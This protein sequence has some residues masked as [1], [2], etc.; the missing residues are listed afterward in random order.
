[1]DSTLRDTIVEAVDREFSQQSEFGMEPSIDDI[2]HSLE[3]L[4]ENSYG[5]T[6]GGNNTQSTSRN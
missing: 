5:E 6:D 3:Q 4:K 1:M 2:I